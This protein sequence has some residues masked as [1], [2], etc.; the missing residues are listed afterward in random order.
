MIIRELKI[1]L[2]EMDRF[3]EFLPWLIGNKSN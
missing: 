3:R 1:P 2:S